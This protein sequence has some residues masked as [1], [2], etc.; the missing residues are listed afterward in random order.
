MAPS[1]ARLKPS[2]P[3]L[4]ILNRVGLRRL[5]YKSQMPSSG[6]GSVR[7]FR[8]AGINVFLHWSWFL[9]SVRLG[10]I[11]K[12]QVERLPQKLIFTRTLRS[13]ETDSRSRRRSKLRLNSNFL[14]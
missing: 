5:C 12:A 14:S 3:K 8:V 4:E 9:V 10:G 2:L 7:L 6:Q 13:R 11:L 1:A